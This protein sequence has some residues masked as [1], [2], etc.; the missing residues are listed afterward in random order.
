M[1]SLIL[2]AQYLETTDDTLV[3]SYGLELHGSRTK[4]NFLC[5]Q[6][7]RKFE[8]PGRIVIGWR[9]Q[10]EA[11]DL[12]AEPTAG[13]RLVERGYTVIKELADMATPHTLVQTCYII[14]PHV[15]DAIAD[16]ER[17]VGALTDFIMNCMAGTISASHQMIENFLLDQALKSKQ[18]QQA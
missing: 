13:I 6:I 8:Q 11:V 2:C 12:S 4:G 1:I 3:E 9:A 18:Q 16:Q 15:Y 17:K 14:R 5:K 7:M 10:A